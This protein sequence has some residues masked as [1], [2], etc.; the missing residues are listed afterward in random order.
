[1][2]LF[3]FVTD[4]KRVTSNQVACLKICKICFSSMLCKTTLD[5][6]LQ[7]EAKGFLMPPFPV[8]VQYNKDKNAA[9]FLEIIIVTHFI[10]LPFNQTKVRPRNF[11]ELSRLRKVLT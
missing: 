1:M 7:F 4:R 2:Y 9:C 5:Q 6:G 8:I 3:V 10:K 11:S